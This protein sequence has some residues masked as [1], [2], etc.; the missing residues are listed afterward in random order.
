MAAQKKKSES[1]V[2]EQP[3]KA[4]AG[5]KFHIPGCGAEIP[6]RSKTCPSCGGS[7]ESKSPTKTV[8]ENGSGFDL[9]KTL[10]VVAAFEEYGKRFKT[11]EEMR[12]SIDEVLQLID[13]AGGENATF[14]LLNYLADR[15]GE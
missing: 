3:K 7:I 15:D 11:W 6:A 9:E 4:K 5:Y 1:A 13:K 8:K 2:S 10:E 12:A 14:R